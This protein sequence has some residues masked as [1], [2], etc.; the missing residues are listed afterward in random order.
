ME[1]AAEAVATV[2]AVA[3]VGAAEAG[4]AQEVQGAEVELG[5]VQVPK[6]ETLPDK[7]TVKMKE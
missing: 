4:K 7:A 2:G 5:K 1:A 3:K 6:A